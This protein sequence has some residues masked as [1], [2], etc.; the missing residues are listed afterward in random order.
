MVL[1]VE[2]TE[3]VSENFLGLVYWQKYWRKATEA[4]AEKFNREIIE[5]TVYKK[6][7]QELKEVHP[8]IML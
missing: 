6:V 7:I 2:D 4:E 1:Y 3:P 5:L 8:E